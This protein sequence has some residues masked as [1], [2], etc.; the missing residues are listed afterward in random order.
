MNPEAIKKKVGE[1]AGSIHSDPRPGNAVRNLHQI[2]LLVE[3]LARGFTGIQVA[4]GRGCPACCYRIPVIHSAVEAAYV[5]KGVKET[6]SRAKHKKFTAMAADETWTELRREFGLPALRPEEGSASF[7]GAWEEM[8]GACPMLEDDG[9]CI[10][11]ERRPVECRLVFSPY[12]CQRPFSQANQTLLMQPV[13]TLDWAVE[14][15]EELLDV[16]EK[17]GFQY[18]RRVGF[19]KGITDLCRQI[20]TWVYGREGTSFP[21]PKILLSVL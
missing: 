9:N 19:L 4:C 7:D 2:F 13:Y 15:A 12:P 8:G 5:E 1:I 3:S 11:Y 14:Q 17:R 16:I 20:D 18:E 6:F 21:L 10:I